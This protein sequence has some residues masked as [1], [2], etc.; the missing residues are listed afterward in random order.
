MTKKNTIFGIVCL[1]LI[2]FSFPV[3]AQ[4]EIDKSVSQEAS[5]SKGGLVRIVSHARKLVIKSWDQPKVKVTL[6]LTYDSSVK[7]RTDEAWFDDLGVSIKPFSNR[8]DILTGNAN[9]G[10]FTTIGKG[11]LNEV[12]VTGKPSPLFR[13]DGTRTLDGG[14]FKYI[15]P[16]HG[17]SIPSSHG[18]VETRIMSIM[19]PSGSKLDIESGSGDVVIGLNADEAKLDISNGTLDAQDFKSL[20]FTGKYC[21]ANFGNIQK[22]EID[23][24]NG[25][26]K[27]QNV[28]DLDLDSKSSSIEYEKGNYVYM[29]SQNDNI[30]IESIAKAEGRKVYGSVK[31]E[32]LS[33]SFDLDGNN[34]DIKIH[35]ISPEVSLIKINNKYG[36]VRLPVRGLNNYYVDFSG[37]Y[38]TIFAP[39]QK[40]VIKDD[41]AA[42]Q[43][44]NM[45][46]PETKRM[47]TSN[48]LQAGGELAPHRF[49]STVG[50]INGKYTKFD[51]TCNYCTLDFK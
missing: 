32:T 8:V 28:G 34:V 16:S 29:R 27:A 30:T 3:K 40:Q 11:S 43:K 31:I 48:A 35:D 26:F 19:V 50:N 36:D 42:V 24:S 4:Q 25:T 6:E 14:N 46:S 38:S 44:D 2:S 22:A 1:V 41:S 47:Y 15:E 37:Y 18:Y 5:V 23:F 21:N 39:F 10:S 7:A 17:K 49:T 51:L 33:G 9:R 20:R 45:M 13:S 12:I